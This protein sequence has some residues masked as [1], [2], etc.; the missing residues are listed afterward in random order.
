MNKKQKLKKIFKYIYR[1]TDES[2]TDYVDME[3]ILKMV[4]Y[5]ELY[6]ELDNQGFFYVEIIYY[7][8]AMEYLKNNDHSLTQSLELAGELGY[9]PGDLNSELLA[10]LLASER[11]KESF[12]SYYDEIEDILTNNE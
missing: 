1:E 12:S 4:N 7:S 8:R 10:S 11:I 2:V 6:D 9:H 3:D 5:D